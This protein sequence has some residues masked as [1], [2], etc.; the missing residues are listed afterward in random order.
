MC[1]NRLKFWQTGRIMVC[2]FISV[3]DLY[4]TVLCIVTVIIL[5]VFSYMQ[6]IA[7]KHQS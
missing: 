4:D 7:H 2:V 1:Y 6:L 3:T 5:N